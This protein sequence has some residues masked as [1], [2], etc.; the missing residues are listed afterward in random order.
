[1]LGRVTKIGDYTHVAITTESG[2]RHWLLTDNEVRRIGDRAD[3]YTVARP[4]PSRVQHLLFWSGAWFRSLFR[5]Q[6]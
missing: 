2:V 5:R 1:M 4:R 6:A 3:K